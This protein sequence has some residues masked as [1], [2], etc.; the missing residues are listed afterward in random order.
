VGDEA[1]KGHPFTLTGEGGLYKQRERLPEILR[2]MGR[3]R[4]EAMGREMV[5]AKRIVQAMATGTHTGKWLDVE[6]GQFA[7]GEGK[8]THGAS[9]GHG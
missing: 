7:L 3:N 5:D 1:A 9:V 8:F 4:L 2:T 6:G